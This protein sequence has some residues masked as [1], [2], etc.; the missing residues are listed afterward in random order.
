MVVTDIVCEGQGLPN[1]ELDYGTGHDILQ[2]LPRIR[3]VVA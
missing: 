2:S 3:S 1:F